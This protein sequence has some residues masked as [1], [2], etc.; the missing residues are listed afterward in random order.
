[1]NYLKLKIFGLSLISILTISLFLNSCGP[2]KF[3]RAD[4]KDSPINE[5]DEKKY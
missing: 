3:E 1:M 5:A 4:V 2:L